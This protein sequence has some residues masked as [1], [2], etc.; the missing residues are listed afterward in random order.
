MASTKYISF[1]QSGDS[2]Y[3]KPNKEVEKIMKPDMQDLY[4]RLQNEILQRGGYQSIVQFSPNEEEHLDT[5]Q[6]KARVEY[7]NEA[8][9]TRP[10]IASGGQGNT[11]KSNQEEWYQKADKDKIETLIYDLKQGKTVPLNNDSLVM[12]NSTKAATGCNNVCT[13]TCSTTCGGTAAA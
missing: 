12:N 2:T 8:M 10:Y 5:N 7:F 1:K 11:Y 3:T 6:D 4:Q 13:G 9:I